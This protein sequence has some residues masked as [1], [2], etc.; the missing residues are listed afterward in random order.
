MVA[1][2]RAFFRLSPHDARALVF[3]AG[4]IT[5][6]IDCLTRSSVNFAIFYC[7]AIVLAGWTRSLRWVWS[8]TLIFMFLTFG[9]IFLVPGPVARVTWVD[10]VNRGMSALALAIV[11][12]P[13]HLRVRNVVALEERL[14]E[15]NETLEKANQQL[16]EEAVI[17]TETEKSL[18][19]SEASL[20]SLS[21][22]LL[23]AQDDE[24][25]RIA[26]ELHDSVGQ[27]LALAK[28]TFRSVL[29]KVN[30]DEEGMQ[31]LSFMSNIL[32]KCVNETR[33]IS[34]LLH[35]PLLDELGF[36]CAAMTYIEG[37]SKRSGIEV[38]ADIPQGLTRLP[39][40]LELVLFRVLQES[41]TNVLRH[42]KS[43]SADV[44]VEIREGEIAL[45]VRDYGMGMPIELLET[46]KRKTDASGVGLSGMRERLSQ[47]NG[48]F[49]I[50]RHEKGTSIRATLPIP[51]EPD[52]AS[53]RGR[54]LTGRR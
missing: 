38:K 37:F 49:E 45:T 35:P 44:K 11:A 36:S 27:S 15:R 25:R 20:R 33:S 4:S 19:A 41:L 6:V 30:Q 42:S 17:R 51:I 29:K 2:L 7:V 47:F 43:S 32:E 13:I 16:M 48:R 54:C 14:K 24:R 8:S 31:A 10:W 21:V 52:P 5:A 22:R 34:Y 26:R 46:Q 23:R 50:E 1:R 28:M 40:E 12:I 9:A 39:G 53:R 18:R 3:L